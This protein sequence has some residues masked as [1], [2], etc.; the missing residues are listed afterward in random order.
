LAWNLKNRIDKYSTEESIFPE[1]ITEKA[2]ATQ[3]LSRKKN[4]CLPKSL[5]QIKDGPTYAVSDKILG[6]GKFGKVKLVQN[7]NDPSDWKALKIVKLPKNPEFI[8]V[9]DKIEDKNLNPKKVKFKNES[10]KK[11]SRNSKRNYHSFVTS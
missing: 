8:V 10:E 2:M 3:R 7:T 1:R 11:E 6:Q 9:P 4:G 5:I